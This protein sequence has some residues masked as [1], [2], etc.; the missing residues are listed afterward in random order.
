MA[1][2][3]EN[4]FQGKE[5]PEKGSSDPK[6]TLEKRRIDSSRINPSLGLESKRRT[7]AGF[8]SI[9]SGVLRI[10]LCLTELRSYPRASQQEGRTDILQTS[11]LT[12]QR[13]KVLFNSLPNAK[14]LGW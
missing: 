7:R 12:S 11:V 5:F 4:V 9:S 10:P 6:P 8:I 3:I 2:F 1:C 13:E 14:N